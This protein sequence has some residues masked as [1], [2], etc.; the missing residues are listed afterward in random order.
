MIVMK[1]G[2]TSVQDA[3]AINQVAEIVKSKIDKKPVVV[4]SAMSKV[5][6]TLLRIAQTAH[7]RDYEEAKKI[8]NELCERHLKTTGELLSA[9]DSSAPEGYRLKDV[10]L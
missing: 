7:E 5:T 8:I 10:E 4:V 1:F 2:G 9:S 3:T 6:D